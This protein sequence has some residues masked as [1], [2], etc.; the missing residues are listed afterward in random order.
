MK[1]CQD[2]PDRFTNLSDY[3]MD[4][5]N[6]ESEGICWV[7]IKH[8][9]WQK[10]TIMYSVKTCLHISFI[11]GKTV[12]NKCKHL[13]DNFHAELNKMNAN[14]FGGPGKNESQGGDFFYVPWMPVTLKAACSFILN[15]LIENVVI[16]I[17]TVMLVLTMMSLLRIQYTYQPHQTYLSCL[18]RE[19]LDV[20]V[21]SAQWKNRWFRLRGKTW[22]YQYTASNMMHFLF[23]LLRIKGL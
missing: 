7:C 1:R 10:P 5:R 21:E 9:S 17:N 11:T 18:L 2:F 20:N 15:I 14:K 4:S 13:R 8:T 6:S 22:S 19:K 12:M 23:N 16:L 3:I